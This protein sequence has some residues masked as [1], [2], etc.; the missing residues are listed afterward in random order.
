MHQHVQ[1]VSEGQACHCHT[2]GV[3]RM[4][5]RAAVKGHVCGAGRLCGEGHLTT[6]GAGLAQRPGQWAP[7]IAVQC[8]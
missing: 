7:Q 3:G 4:P 1:G 2:G 8:G 6:A 5:W